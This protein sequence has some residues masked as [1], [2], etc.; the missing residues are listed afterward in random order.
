MGDGVAQQVADE[1]MGQGRRPGPRDRR[2][3]G[4]RELDLFAVQQRCI[5]EHQSFQHGQ[6]RLLLAGFGAG[7]R[8]AC[9][10]QHRL[11]R[12]PQLPD[13]GLDRAHHR[14]DLGGRQLL[15]TVGRHAEHGQRR[16]QLVAHVGGEGLLAR[17]ERARAVVQ[18]VQPAG[19]LAD[20]VMVESE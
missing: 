16:A 9:Q 2:R 4:E 14:L 18:Q 10:R 11:D 15:Q 13:G 8:F 3:H 1:Q 6:Q 5:R 20:L 12:A 7:R 17:D 19:Q